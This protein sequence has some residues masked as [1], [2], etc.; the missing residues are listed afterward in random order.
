[1][2]KL[3]SKLPFF[4]FFLLLFSEGRASHFMGADMTYECL[5]N[6]CTYRIYQSTY[7][8]CAGAA[9]LFYLPPGNCDANPPIPAPNPFP[10]P[11]VTATGTGCTPPSVSGWILE[12]Y[13]EVTPVCPTYQTQCFT[14]G[15]AINGVVGATYYADY[16]LCGSTC[17]TI[18][19]VFSS[20]C[21]NY[22]ITSGA[23]GNSIYVTT[24]INLGFSPCNSSPIFSV[25]PVPYI[26][27]GQTFTFSQGAF[28][29]DGDSLVYSLGPCLQGAANTVTY[30]AGFTPTQ[31][32]G[33]GWTTS[34]NPLTGDVTFTP[35]PNGPLVTGVLCVYVTEWRNING[36]PT[37]IG[38]VERDI[39]V[40]VIN[41]GA[42]NTP[43]SAVNN[44]PAIQNGVSNLL[45][46][47]YDPITN[48]ITTCAGYPASLDF[49]ITDPNATG[50]AGADTVCVSWTSPNP[51]LQTGL[52]FANALTPTV[53]EDTVCNTNTPITVHLQL[54]QNLPP[55]T[56]SVTIYAVDNACPI[57]GQNQYTLLFNVLCCNVEPI[58]STTITNCNTI[59]V[60]TVPSCGVAP[61]TYVW[62]GNNFTFNPVPS[63][64]NFV[65]TFPGPGT[66]IYTCTLT[67]FLGNGG[68]NTD[69]IVIAN[70]SVADAGPDVVLCP[71]Q[72]AVIGTPGLS[73]NTYSWYSVPNNVGFLTATNI[74][75]P[76]VG[77][78]IFTNIPVCVDYIVV[79]T[80]SLGCS[81]SD[82]T[83]ICYNPTPTSP[84]TITSPICEGSCTTVQY[85]GNPPAGATYNWNF[86]GGIASPG[87]NSPGP[88]QVCFGT[89]G[90][91]NISLEVTTSI[92]CVSN[93]TT[94]SVLV[95][96]IP[97][98]TFSI[99]GPVCEGENATITYTGNA[100]PN[101]N[102]VW[103]FDGGVVVSGGQG[104][105]PHTVYWT[106]AGSHLVS[107]VVD[108][109]GCQGSLFSQP[110]TVSEIPDACFTAPNNICVNTPN[111]VVYNCSSG[112]NAI[113]NWDFGN[114]VILSGSGQGPITLSWTTPG[115]QPVCLTVTENGCVSN[116]V[117]QTVN[118]LSN[119][120]PSI[121]PVNNQC[122]LNNSFD[123]QYNGTPGVTL[124]SWNFG[125]S[126]VPPT[127][128]GT[129][130][131]TG[132]HY[133][134]PG[135]KTVSVYVQQN[136]CSSAIAYTSFT[137]L[138]EPEAAFTISSSSVC[139][140]EGLNIN[141]TGASLSQQQA[142]YWN[143]GPCANPQFSTLQNPGLVQY[144]CS[145]YQFVTLVV[146][147]LGCLDTMVQQVYV[148]DRPLVNAGTDGDLCDGSSAQLDATVTGGTPPY[149]Y[150][151]W[152]NP[153]NGGLS[154][155]F[156]EDPSVVPTGNTVYY[157]TVTDGYG[158]S[159]NVDSVFVAVKP[160]PQADAGPDKSMCDAP[161]SF[162]VFLNGGVSAQNQAPA[163]YTYSWV[164]NTS[165]NC[166]MILGQEIL[167]SPL[168]HPNQTT[169]Y[170]LYVTA[171]NGC[172][173]IVTTLDTLSTTTVW[174]NPL[175]IVEAGPYTEICYG[176]T[177]QLNGFAYNAGPN[178]VY[179]WT[180]NGPS[181]GIADPTDPVSM[182][183]PAFTQTYTLS[184]ESNGCFGADTVTIKV[185]TLP[186]ASIEPPVWDI[187]QGA[188]VTL[189][190][191]ADG[192]PNGTIGYV[193]SWVPSTGLSDPHS[194][195]PIASPDTT[196]TYQ[197]IAG[198]TASC[199][200]FVDQITITI[201]PTPIADITN[202]DT[203]L[204]YGDSMILFGTHSFV[205]TLI[206]SPVIYQWTPDS[207]ISSTAATSPWVYPKQ[208]TTYTLT[209]SVA[210]ECPTSDHIT[211]VVNP[212]LNPSAGGD[213][214]IC[215]GTSVTLNGAGGNGAAT[216]TWTPSIYLSDSSIVN[217][218]STPLVTTTYMLTVNEGLCSDSAKVTVTVNPTPTA[219]VFHS[220]LAGCLPLTVNFIENSIDDIA[221]I[222]DF[223]DGSA[224]VNEAITNHTYTQPGSFTVSY[225]A[226]GQGGC[227]RS[228]TI[229]PIIVSDTSFAAFTSNPA[230]TDTLLLPDAAVTFTDISVNPIT[231][232]WDFGDGQT[233]SEQ[234]PKHNFPTPGDYGVSL[235]VTNELGC[236]STA[237]AT[238]HVLEPGIFAPNIF[239]PN[240]DGFF[241]TWVVSYQGTDKFSLRVYDRWGNDVFLSNSPANVW[242]GTQKGKP[243]LPGVYYYTLKIGAKVY[244]GNV[245]VLR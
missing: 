173:S 112:P 37:Q 46:G 185:N 171:A 42:T 162:G 228:T 128:L 67:D 2:A 66:Y 176:E 45:Q 161:N 1:M 190:G 29:P 85:A 53:Q 154:N 103:N 167:P 3:F 178:Y 116:T 96:P 109:F 59:N 7:L 166:G 208:T 51:A 148:H 86:G 104:P 32:L 91:Y 144:N 197:L 101:A 39:Q 70:N 56:Y 175:P 223:G 47:T 133:V 76:T 158:C 209:T 205:G 123:F 134:T 244:N 138:E 125:S 226:I 6:G 121:V 238:Y 20:C 192:D 58:I 90:T 193:Y 35:S 80:D 44:P 216:Y 26:C 196:T 117:C 207:E 122:F 151:W 108:E 191:L 198:S 11:F 111:Q 165:P 126:A 195:T 107:L 186:T 88:H 213:V 13:E 152:S 181:A 105:G 241:D 212:S 34:I 55:G 140:G 61:F 113:Y 131:P 98:S 235:T 231:W 74:A 62:T 78:N 22:A 64:A 57:L 214:A 87:G 182:I 245:T 150:S 40:T 41:C 25:D 69:T 201:K 31:P 202:L 49:T 160:R 89:A 83:T 15:A 99:T 30:N 19:L 210:G 215:A 94:S 199:I 100:S 169:I 234:H 232:L 143:F 157:F 38:Q 230:N 187:C 71:N 179:Q 129:A 242:D 102:Y 33:P 92:G 79:A 222:W 118:V 227:N 93:I 220:N 236:S 24:T 221:Y 65:Y 145:G 73:G 23:G 124:Y 177:V 127:M 243:V 146:D 60:S 54:P 16:N 52:L 132:I 237:V 95:N 27:A 75:E 206:G 184:A 156:V 119:P 137:V 10:A 50:L 225:T 153:V 115:P 135:P 82:T 172:T 239:T 48:V 141:Y 17:T 168:V 240:G 97:T 68:S 114:A 21:R 43:P 9:T 84:F 194:P 136:G 139:M 147:H 170:T 5:A 149:F 4:L 203:T 14:P 28:D 106:T 36:V 229:G 174:V 217:P 211:V 77:L 189:N 18:Q 159:S 81:N 224:V 218:I 233:S 12:C 120:V 204:C 180:P 130:N 8:D 155:Q 200:G 164:C 183:A 63:G 219:D 163:P 142:Y 110:I 72:T 188:S